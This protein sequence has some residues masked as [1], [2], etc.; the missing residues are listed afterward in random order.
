LWY[1]REDLFKRAERELENAL[2]LTGPNE[3]IYATFG[4]LY[5]QYVEAG[6]QS[7]VDY[8]AKAHEYVDKVFAMNPESPY[9]FSLTGLLKYRV[10]D[11][12]NAVVNYKKALAL[13]P[14]DANSLQMLAYCYTL[15]GR[16]NVAHPLLDQLISID[17]ITP[18]N[19]AVYGFMFCMQGRFQEGLVH[20]KKMYDISSESPV[21]RT[22][23]AWVLSMDGQYD[24]A[25]VLLL[26]SC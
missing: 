21:F 10:G 3:F 18:M 1:F 20:Y 5:N 6:I 14:N 2:S 24:A 16:E 4:W 23:Y 25:N 13:D 26:L 8:I 12:Q 9:G 7:D 22:F 11:F 17:P 19:H 15:S